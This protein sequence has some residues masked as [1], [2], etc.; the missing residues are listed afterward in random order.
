MQFVVIEINAVE[1]SFAPSRFEEIR[2]WNP[3]A[4]GEESAGVLKF[5]AAVAGVV[6][7]NMEKL[8]QE[9]RKQCFVSRPG[10]L[11]F[12]PLEQEQLSLILGIEKRISCTLGSFRLM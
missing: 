6:W 5:V 2:A 12:Y 11:S 10:I 4:P 3:L 8:G 9:I 7:M 1:T